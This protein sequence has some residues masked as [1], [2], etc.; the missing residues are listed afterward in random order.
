M[1]N[2]LVCKLVKRCMYASLHGG[3]HDWIRRL[4]VFLAARERGLGSKPRRATLKPKPSPN[5]GPP[6]VGG[7][8]IP[9]RS[10]ARASPLLPCLNRSP[11]TG[12]EDN[13][14]MTKRVQAALARKEDRMIL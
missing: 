13:E 9:T 8:L 6:G 11:A 5:P 1:K 4:A 7:S 2:R 14:D 12:G 3:N 10:S